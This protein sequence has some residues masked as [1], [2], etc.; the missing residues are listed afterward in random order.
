V[1]IQFKLNGAIAVPEPL[2]S[3]DDATPFLDE[4]LLRAKPCFTCGTPLDCT[5]RDALSQ[6]SSGGYDYSDGN[7]EG[8]VQCENEDCEGHY[9]TGLCLG[10]PALQ[11]GKFHNHCMVGRGVSSV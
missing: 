8:A 6:P 11:T 2:I 10:K 7:Q 1:H 9:I 4:F 5:V 3:A